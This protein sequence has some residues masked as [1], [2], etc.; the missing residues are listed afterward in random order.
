MFVTIKVI[1]F[2]LNNISEQDFLSIVLYSLWVQGSLVDSKVLS[3]KRERLVILLIILMES[4]V[5]AFL[6]ASLWES[7]DQAFIDFNP[8]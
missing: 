1:Q 4:W 8:N 6:L 7:L 5:L 2:F 3:F